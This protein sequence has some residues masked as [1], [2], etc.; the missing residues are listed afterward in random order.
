[1]VYFLFLILNPI[2]PI[3]PA[4]IVNISVILTASAVFVFLPSSFKNLTVYVVVSGL[5]RSSG[6][7]SL[8]YSADNLN[9]ILFLFA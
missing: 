6:N 3:R 2:V 4:N 7:M 9:A 8:S 1:M 5:I